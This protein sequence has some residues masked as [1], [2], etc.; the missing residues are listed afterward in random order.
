ML[1]VLLPFSLEGLLDSMIVA[2]GVCDYLE[3]LFQNEPSF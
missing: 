3:F 2:I 1:I